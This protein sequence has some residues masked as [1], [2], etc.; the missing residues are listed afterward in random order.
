[1]ISLLA[2]VTGSVAAL[3]ATGLVPG[4]DASSASGPGC[5][6]S[7]KRG[8]A[9]NNASTV[10][11]LRGATP[12]TWAYSW[13]IFD[14]GVLPDGVEFVPMVWGP[15][16]QDEW[17]LAIERALDTGSR[18]LLGFN[19]PDLSSQA[20]LSPDDAA[21]HYR[22]LLTPFSDQATLVS[23]AVTN[24]N[25]PAL[26]LNWMQSFL[27]QCAGC[28]I[29]ALAV[30]W[31]GDTATDFK[32]YVT[33]ALGLA[34]QYGLQSVWVTEFA[35]NSDLRDQRS[36]PASEKFLQEVLP[37]LDAEAG[38]GRYAYFM[39]GEDYLVKGNGR[40]ATGVVYTT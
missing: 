6:Q 15:Q 1:M 21:R 27:R 31:Y 12:A 4:A 22:Q 25:G 9:Y 35:L 8:A 37:W 7:C 24:G 20:S 34:G 2:F 16:T 14:N 32:R 5:P 19:E 23:P 33:Q 17:R 36:S 39:C 10:S 38:V 30:H 13:S 28:N 29:S 3:L 18:H 26:G 40:T 11:A